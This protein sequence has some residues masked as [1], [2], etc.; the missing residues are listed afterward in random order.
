MGAAIVWIASALSAAVAAYAS[1]VGFCEARR[2]WGRA[3]VWQS[4]GFVMFGVFAGL[5]AW[6]FIAGAMQGRYLGT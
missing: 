1:F 4:V 6:A 2:A 3:K 5:T